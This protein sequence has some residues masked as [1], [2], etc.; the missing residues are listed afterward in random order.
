MHKA[1]QG[2]AVP[3]TDL[4]YGYVESKTG[5]FSTRSVNRILAGLKSELIEKCCWRRTALSTP[6]TDLSLDEG[7]PGWDVQRP[8]VS[9]S[10][11]WRCSSCRCSSNS[12]I[13]IVRAQSS[14]HDFRVL[15][16]TTWRPDMVGANAV[17]V[18]LSGCCPLHKERFCSENHR[19][20]FHNRN[21]YRRPDPN[22]DFSLPH[23]VTPLSLL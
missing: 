7:R 20:E 23:P 12:R 14:P 9:F 15:T 18:L 10:G 3:A 16:E 2:K 5:K 17:A 21:R 8:S 1:H 4:F 11:N 19:V 6:R 13:R 22:S